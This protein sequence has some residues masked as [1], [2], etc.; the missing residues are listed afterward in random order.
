MFNCNDQNMQKII[1]N[2]TMSLDGFIAGPGIT[3][4]Q[5]M[6]IHGQRLHDWLFTAKT[7]ADTKILDEVMN[8][9]GA[10]LL[11]NV[12]YSTAINGAWEG[13]TPFNIPAFVLCSEKPKTE[14]PGFTYITKGMQDAL[15]KA[16]T[17]AGRKTI[18]IMGGA[19]TARQFIKAGLVDE[20]HLH[21]APILL[22]AGTRL[23]E[24]IGDQPI[25]LK[26][27]GNHRY[28]SSDPY[29]VRNSK[30]IVSQKPG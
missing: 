24:H 29:H 25:S 14:V 9:S 13:V 21:I 3:G 23:F 4:K 18:W 22:N 17:E 8:A 15:D 20:L 16:K 19:Y 12:T 2:I 5:P 11:G 27:N 28:T 30:I 7:E 26:K 1:V 10:V 6:G